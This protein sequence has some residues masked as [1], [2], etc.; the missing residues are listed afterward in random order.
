[1]IKPGLEPLK[2][3]KDEMPPRWTFSTKAGEK[4]KQGKED[5]K[6]K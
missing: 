4:V 1:M 5:R 6:G 2:G 3:D